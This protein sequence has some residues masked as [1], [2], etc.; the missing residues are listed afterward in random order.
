VLPTAF[1]NRIR[2]A[3][4]ATRVRWGLD[5]I[6]I[7]PLVD[8]LLSPREQDLHNDVRSDLAFAMHATLGV[9]IAGAVLLADGLVND[10]LTWRRGALVALLLLAGYP[11]YRLLAV[12]AAERFGV[13]M[14]ASV[15]LHR[16]ELYRS[17]G[18][19]VPETAADERA[20]ALA[21]SQALLYGSAMPERRAAAAV[22]E[23]QGGDPG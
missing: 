17:L 8:G 19:E 22:A 18:Y 11:I 7:W 15:D 1:G 9:W 21:I 23:P 5:H 4:D 13:E 3:E 16:L 14:R 20:L 12:D 10:E 6:A 2:A